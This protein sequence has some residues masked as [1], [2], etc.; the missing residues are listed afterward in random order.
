MSKIQKEFLFFLCL[1]FIVLL[2]GGCKTQNK[3]EGKIPITTSSDEAKEQ[4]LKGR[5]LT[6][7]LQGQESL[8]Y[9]TNA[10]N[11]D[12]NFALAYL[13]RAQNQPTA[14]A[15]FADLNKAVSL[16]DKVSEGEKL[17]IS[18]FEAGVNA[19]PVKQKEDYE[20]LVTMYPDDERAHMLLGN[21]YYGQQNYQ[22]AVE[23]YNKAAQI[24]SSFSL[25]YNMLG[26]GNRQLMNYDAAEKAFRKYIE[27]IPNDPNPYDSYAE[28]LMKEGKYDQS[29][30][31]YQKALTY[32]PH[33]VSS[34]LGIAANEM[35]KGNYDSSRAEIQKLYESARNNGEKRAANFAMA[36]TYI[37]E[38]NLDMALN[39]IQKNYDI[40]DMSNDFA[41]MS[42]DLVNKGTI[43]LAM[44]KSKDA[45]DNF[46]QA[47]D[48]FNKSAS[49]QQLKDNVKLG[50]LYNEAQVALQKKDFKTATAKADEFM[51]GVKAINNANQIKLAHQLNGMI[52][53]AQKKADDCLSELGQANQQ[54]T[55]NLYRMA[56][57]Y[58]IKGDK[59]KAKEYCE[60]VIN[61]NPLPNLNSA[62]ALYKAKKM[63]KML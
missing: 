5:N 43:L 2:L 22:S 40:A 28:L 29:I 56:L 15:F 13:N 24:D 7:T 50:L 48:M 14:K 57:A 38:G 34:M 37:D 58:Q 25:A 53:L 30:D 63:M 33:F 20:K 36:V 54:N 26:Y 47:V 27:L 49:P 19:N 32:N 61:F 46:Q 51:N 16:A 42:G 8:Q 12:S 18:G 45:L 52:A 59:E 44:G 39:E 23:Q 3:D 55:Y 62:F 35:Y 17:Q 31:N 41:S 10:I 21:F 11:A 4:Y 60:K 6:E 1:L 9:Y